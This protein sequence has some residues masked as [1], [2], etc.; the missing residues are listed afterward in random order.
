MPG[1]RASLVGSKFRGKFIFTGSWV[2]DVPYKLIA[3]YCVSK[4]GVWMLI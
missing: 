3:P 4:A 1:G 2:Q